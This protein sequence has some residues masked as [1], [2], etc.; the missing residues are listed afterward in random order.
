METGWLDLAVASASDDT[1]LNDGDGAYVGT[2]G[3][4]T[5]NATHQGTF[6]TQ[7]VEQNESLM[8]R[9]EASSAWTG[10]LSS[11]SIVWGNA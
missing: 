11:V 6:V 10:Y 9:L 8:L 5:I 4:L 2:P 3:T 7:T 1:Q